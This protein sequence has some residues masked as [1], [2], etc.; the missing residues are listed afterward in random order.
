VFRRTSRFVE[1]EWTEAVI[2]NGHDGYKLL[3]TARGL[4]EKHT[5]AMVS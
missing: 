2:K 5:K 4:I 3:Q 1:P